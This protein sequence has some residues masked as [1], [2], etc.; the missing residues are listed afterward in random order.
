MLELTSLI[1]LI[2]SIYPLYK[3]F[4][5][6]ELNLFD[7]LLLFV[8]L[9][10]AIT[11]LKNGHLVFFTTNVVIEVFFYYFTF[12]II[13]VS[14]DLYWTKKYDKARSIINITNYI[15][16]ISN[17]KVTKRGIVFLSLCMIIS[18]VYYVPNASL[19]LSDTEDNTR[20]YEASSI[21][22]AFT[23][24]FQAIGYISAFI[25]FIG[26]KNGDKDRIAL[27][28]FLCFI[29]LCV[30]LP[31]RIL[32][33]QLL[34]VGLI[35]YSLFRNKITLKKCL[36]VSILAG[37]FFS[38]YYPFYNVIRRN[39][40]TFDTTQPIQSMIQVVDYGI[41]NFGEKSKDASELTAERS[42]GIYQAMYMIMQKNPVCRMGELTYLSIDVA[43]PKVLNPNKGAGTEEEIQ[44]MSGSL[45]DIADSYFL[46]GFAEFN[47]FGCIYAILLYLFVFFSYS[48]YANFLSGLKFGTMSS[49]YVMFSLFDVTW[50]VESKFEGALAWFFGSSFLIIMLYFLER[51]KCFTV[52]MNN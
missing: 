11:P 35:Y 8:T 48:K 4:K 22:M 36:L 19:F 28:L 49:I 15:N 38:I 3:C 13:L 41:D 33:Y 24:I 27:L 16:A 51:T 40:I 52:K 47:F 34:C 12:L 14:I 18:A 50:E 39:D 45:F 10:F 20:S 30:F 42:L 2:P 32:T 23:N 31:R 21:L 25:F 37:L 29:L 26:R 43:I 5:K 6:E 17:F 9:H 7:L 1:G 44:K 46:L